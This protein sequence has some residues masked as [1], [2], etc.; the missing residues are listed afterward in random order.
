MFE[1]CDVDEDANVAAESYDP[2]EA[3]AGVVSNMKATVYVLTVCAMLPAASAMHEP[4]DHE[5]GQWRIW[6]P[7]TILVM[8]LLLL[9]FGVGRG[10]GARAERVR[11]AAQ[12]DA[13]HADLDR[14]ALRHD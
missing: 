2:V 6:N 14:L 10:L 13:A 7:L 1:E 9:A 11:Q 3:Y 12:L 8:L 4:L 5:Y